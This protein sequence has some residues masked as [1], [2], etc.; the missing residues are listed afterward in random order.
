LPSP[1]LGGWDECYNAASVEEEAV[2]RTS[3]E[4]EVSPLSVWFSLIFTSP[5]LRI[6]RSILR[7]MTYHPSR[8]HLTKSSQHATMAPLQT[9]PRVLLVNSDVRDKLIKNL[10]G[11][12]DKGTRKSLVIKEPRATLKNKVH[13]IVGNLLQRLHRDPSFDQ[14]VLRLPLHC[15]TF[16]STFPTLQPEFFYA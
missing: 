15:A 4:I 5:G 2:E 16:T 1:L 9:H 6:L 7:T 3:G 13:S 10:R 12:L 8:D 14:T 11:Q